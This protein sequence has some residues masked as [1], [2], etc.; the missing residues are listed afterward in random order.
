MST[1]KKV[2]TND[3]KSSYVKPD[4]DAKSVMQAT[5]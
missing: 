2:G 1:V 5:Q 4:A 3:F